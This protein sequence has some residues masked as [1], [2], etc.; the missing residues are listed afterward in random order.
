MSPILFF[1]FFFTCIGVGKNIFTNKFSSSGIYRYF[2][3]S[4]RRVKIWRKTENENSYHIRTY[5][6]YIPDTIVESNQPV[7][8]NDENITIC[9]KSE[10]TPNTAIKK[11]LSDYSPGVISREEGNQH[12]ENVFPIKPS[13]KRS[14]FE[15][16]DSEFKSFGSDDIKVDN[17]YNDKEVLEIL[18]IFRKI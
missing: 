9:S 17:D 16:T 6:S 11:K 18:P 2:N 3:S 5:H 15:W 8:I 12:N 4:V 1:I 13:A 7:H 10:S 14:L